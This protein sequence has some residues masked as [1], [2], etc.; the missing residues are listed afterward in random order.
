LP[1]SSRAALRYPAL[2]DPP[3][4]PQDLGFL[5]SDTDAQ[6]Y[7]A[8]SCTSGTR[9][10]GMGTG[11]HI[12]ETDTGAEYVWNGAAWVTP[13]N[14]AGTGGGGGSTS[15]YVFG[16][17]SEDDPQSIPFNTNTPVRFSDTDVSS[18][19]VAR[20]TEGSGHRFTVSQTGFY[21]VDVTVRLA[22]ASETGGNRYLELR[23]AGNTVRHAACAVPG[24]ATE[25]ATLHLSCPVL[26]LTAND[27]L[28][29]IMAQTRGAGT[30]LSTQPTAGGAPVRGWQQ[31]RIIKVG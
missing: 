8:F 18:A 23:N 13:T 30:A 28:M 15:P 12:W 2:A 4:V 19:A 25:A 17:W 1:T 7:R 6:L 20:A 3:N 22:A 5:A 10:T 16:Q 24:A 27:T 9:P 29:V 14:Y 26:S 21:A 31:I 11:F